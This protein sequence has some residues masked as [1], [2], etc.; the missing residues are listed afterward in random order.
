M[1]LVPPESLTVQ[2]SIQGRVTDNFDAVASHVLKGVVRLVEVGCE[3]SPGV[4]L[5]VISVQVEP[6]FKA[7]H[8]LP[9]V[10]CCGAFVAVDQVDNVRWFAG[11]GIPN[12]EES[13]GLVV[14]ECGSWRVVL[15]AYH[16]SVFLTLPAAGWISRGKLR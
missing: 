16:A 9:H 8:G 3:M 6:C 10:A 14:S 1:K 13:A 15:L 2:A 5:D 12:V 4:F 7:V 11:H